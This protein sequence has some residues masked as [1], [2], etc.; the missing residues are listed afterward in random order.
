MSG[1]EVESDQLASSTVE[2]GSVDKEGARTT[3]EDWTSWEDTIKRVKVSLDSV[4]C[5]YEECIKHLSQK[6]KSTEST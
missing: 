2:T 5:C 6:D 3:I 4:H 1:R